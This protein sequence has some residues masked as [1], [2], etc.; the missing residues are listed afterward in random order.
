MRPFI[1]LFCLLVAACEAPEIVDSAAMRPEFEPVDRMAMLRDVTDRV[2]PVA[3]TSCEAKRPQNECA[4]EVRVDSR[5]D[6]PINAYLTTDK[7]GRPIITVTLAL[8]Q[9]VR[10]PDE[11]AFVIGHEAGHQIERHGTGQILSAVEGVILGTLVAYK[12]GLSGAERKA[13]QKQQAMRWVRKRSHEI[14][15][16]ADRIGAEFAMR[17]GY[18]PMAGAAALS[19][20][21]EPASGRASLHPR[22]SDRAKAILDLAYQPELEL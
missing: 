9:D 11:L 19:R 10:S 21:P 1:L 17:S 2:L 15:F 14:E 5:P 6:R 20:W 16:E 8:L 3:T 13:V 18:D 7:G 12:R 4:F 22:S